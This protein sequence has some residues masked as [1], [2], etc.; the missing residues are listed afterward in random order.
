MNALT[1]L[2]EQLASYT[3]SLRTANTGRSVELLAVIDALSDTIEIINEARADMPLAQRAEEN[4]MNLDEKAYR[5]CLGDAAGIVEDNTTAEQQ[6]A[7][8]DEQLDDCIRTVARS[9]EH[10]DW[11]YAGQEGLFTWLDD[12]GFNE[13]EGE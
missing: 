12:N 6:A 5:L 13:S 7:F 3:A 9:F 11:N 8:T 1:I 2:N 10:I 4:G